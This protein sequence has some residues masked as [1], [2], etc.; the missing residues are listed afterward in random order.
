MGFAE[1]GGMPVRVI[2]ARGS[3]RQP[4][5]GSR[6]TVHCVSATGVCSEMIMREESHVKYHYIQYIDM[7][8]AHF[9]T[10]RSVSIR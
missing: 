10:H 8:C 4:D 5:T 3:S 6:M 7:L 9:F 2:V 1:A